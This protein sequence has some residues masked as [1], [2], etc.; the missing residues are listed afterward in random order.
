MTSLLNYYATY[1]DGVPVGSLELKLVV[2][3]AEGLVITEQKTRYHHVVDGTTV[4]TADESKPTYY[5]VDGLSLPCFNP[6]H[7]AMQAYLKETI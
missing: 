7:I 1:K 2:A 3:K 5:F 4:T 6:Y